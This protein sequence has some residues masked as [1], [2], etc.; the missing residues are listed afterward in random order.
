MGRLLRVYLLVAMCALL[1]T[2]LRLIYLHMRQSCSLACR[3]IYTRI[4]KFAT[5]AEYYL[6]ALLVAEGVVKEEEINDEK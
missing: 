4:E 1:T 5:K 2:I 6:K 3:S